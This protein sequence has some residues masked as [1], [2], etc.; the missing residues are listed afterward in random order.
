ME[1]S[2][3]KNCKLIEIAK[4]IVHKQRENF[5]DVMFVSVSSLLRISK[6]KKSMI[7]RIRFIYFC[8]NTRVNHQDIVYFTLFEDIVCI[9]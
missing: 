3:E 4:N 8:I 2:K 7:I 1:D 6:V 9:F 5:P